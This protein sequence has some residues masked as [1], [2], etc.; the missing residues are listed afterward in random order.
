[1]PNSIIGNNYGS[2]TQPPNQVSDNIITV[3]FVQGNSVNNYP[4]APGKTVLLIDYDA[5]KFW[6]KG[7]N[8]NG[9]YEPIRE[10]EFTE[11]TMQPNN[12][13]IDT[14]QLV[15]RKEFDEL[16]SVIESIKPILEDLKG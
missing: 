9:M 12:E 13:P 4:I 15:S 1:M 7:R 5:K 6:I 16:K 3:D 14:S 11:K 8:Q 10:F 2:Y